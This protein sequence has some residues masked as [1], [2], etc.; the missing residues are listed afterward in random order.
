MKNLK[1]NINFSKNKD[2]ITQDIDIGY[3]KMKN[4]LFIN[5]SSI[6]SERFTFYS[7][8]YQQYFNQ[9]ILKNFNAVAESDNLFNLDNNNE[10]YGM[11]NLIHLIFHEVGHHVM[12]QGFDNRFYKSKKL[13]TK[14]IQRY[15]NYFSEQP[16]GM[17]AFYKRRIESE[18]YAEK[19][20]L[21]WTKKLQI[22]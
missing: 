17:D 6:F 22:K 7:N 13:I 18:Q 12:N 2:L 8:F 19:F 3:N 4:L 16:K 5:N 20:R 21:Y 11:K 10:Y 1:L 15:Y 9:K 14:S